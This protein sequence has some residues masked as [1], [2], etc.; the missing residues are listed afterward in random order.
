MAVK[1]ASEN[2][3]V[4]P[5]HVEEFEWPSLELM[6]CPYPFYD[7]L[8]AEAPVYKFPGGGNQYLV[9]RWQDVVYV[10]EH[11][12]IFD[13]GSANDLRIPR[14][15]PTAAE[16]GTQTY[17]STAMAGTDPPEHKLKRSLA[18]K[19]VS[20]ERL[21]SYEEM[22][23][24]ISDERIDA[25]IGRGE[26]E[27]FSEFC[28]ALPILVICE[29]LGLPKERWQDF[30]LWG[31]REGVGAI[32]L[33]DE[34]LRKQRRSFANETGF[35]EV[36]ILDRY[37]NP[38]NDFLTEFV[39]AQV[40]RDGEL[41]LEYLVADASLLLF[42]GNV[43]T[44]HMMASMMMLLIQNPDMLARVQA[45]HSLIKNLVEE[46]L[47]LESPVQYTHRHVKVDA[48]IG[49]VRIPAGSHV[50]SVLASGNRDGDRFEE[51]EAF[52]LDR[53]DTVKHQLAFGRGIH[54]CLGAPLA[55]REGR[56]AF[57]QLLTRLKNLQAAP[58]KN[59]FTHIESWGFR[60][61]KA[62]YIEFDPA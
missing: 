15:I 24:R 61:P 26:A 20:P 7:A 12:E 16:G 52:S 45:D 5:V 1:Q 59:D 54:L 34:A 13:Q 29:I 23:R 30:R 60:A 22:I 49:G 3:A 51:P 28:D 38:R 43:T 37:K 4:C 48:E 42:A 32:Y 27:F 55:R 10:N 39:Q 40:K 62:V 31:S 36:E 53:K 6:E 57:E 9:S 2:Q 50:T 41:R 33:S 47:R 44:T 58:A 11:P 46:A 14:G 25:F 35:M 18:M 8:R 21:D 19:F 56:L 17:R